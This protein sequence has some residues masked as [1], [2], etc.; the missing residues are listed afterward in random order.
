MD[1]RYE[2]YGRA[3]EQKQR[4]KSNKRDKS[5]RAK[6]AKKEEEAR[7]DVERENEGRGTYNKFYKENPRTPPP[8]PAPVSSRVV[9][10]Q[11]LGLK[12]DQDVPMTIRSTYRRL[13]LRYHPD[14]NSAPD[15]TRIFREITASYEIL[16]A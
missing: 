15:A 4:K 12:E 6:E 8:E 3:F 14:K 13:A 9:H 7:R 2:K 10:L 5:S 16:C 11:V 1:D